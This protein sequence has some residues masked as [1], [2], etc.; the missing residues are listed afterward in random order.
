MRDAEEK[1]RMSEDLDDA[2]KVGFQPPNQ[3]VGAYGN[4]IRKP[5]TNGKTFR[6]AT[7][8]PAVEDAM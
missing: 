1:A 5:F 8:S 7:S 4:V 3:A 6:P 2:Q